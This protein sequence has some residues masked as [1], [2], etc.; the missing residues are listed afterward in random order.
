MCLGPLCLWQ[1]QPWAMEYFRVRVLG[2]GSPE[3]LKAW[4]ISC[5]K[6]QATWVLSTTGSQDPSSSV[7]FLAIFHFLEWLSRA[8]TVP[9]ETAVRLPGKTNTAAGTTGITQDPCRDNLSEGLE[10]IFKFLLVHG[11]RQVRNVQ[12]GRILF[13]LLRQNRKSA[14]TFRQKET[15]C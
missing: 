6:T 10:H 2:L 3:L 9:K 14:V 8:T 12:V 7:L 5:V 11:Q 1:F 4:K 13:L 15:P